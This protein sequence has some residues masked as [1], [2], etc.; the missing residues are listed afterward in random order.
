[1]AKKDFKLNIDYFMFEEKTRK[2]T[3]SRRG[4]ILN[5]YFCTINLIWLKTFNFIKSGI[6]SVSL[7]FFRLRL[8]NSEPH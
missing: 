7:N 1:M 2:T 5:M 4:E 3:K 6:N 8:K